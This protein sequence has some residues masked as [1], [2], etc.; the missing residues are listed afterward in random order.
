LRTLAV[1]AIAGCAFGGA[2]LHGQEPMHGV[3]V[4]QEIA[5]YDVPGTSLASV[6]EILNT[7]RLEGPDAPPSQGLT[8]YYIKPEW[9]AQA[10]GGACRVARAEIFVEID[11]T[12]PRWATVE[13]R[14]A[15]EQESWSQIERAIRQHEY[16]HR[17]LTI[18]AAGVLLSALRGLET[19][20]CG[21]L[22]D[23]VASALS[24]A[25]A[26]LREAHAILDRETPPRL[27][28]GPGD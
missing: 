13:E 10:S 18:D 5:Y 21:I 8:S 24:I 7:A 28:V 22:R 6:I 27:S 25:D 4:D 19:R 11:I 17:D 20:G 26:R 3:R 16:A 15:H 14:P 12:L 9:S 23:A 1:L 2:G